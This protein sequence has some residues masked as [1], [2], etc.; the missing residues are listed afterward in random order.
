MNRPLN[1]VYLHSHDTGQ[2]IEPYGHPVETPALA[3][4]AR[5][6]VLFRN[7]TC[8]APTCSPSRAALLTGLCPHQP[9]N[10]ML[11]LAHFGDWRLEDPSRHLA[12][13]LQ[14]HGYVTALAGVQH[15]TGA[16]HEAIHGLG[17]RELLNHD[18]PNGS[19]VEEVTDS[20]AC[21]FLRRQASAGQPFFLSV[22]FS[23][24]HRTGDV[25]NFAPRRQLEKRGLPPASDEPC[26]S[27]V[28]SR[29][30]RAPAPFYDSPA[31][32]R[33]WARFR[34]G[35]RILDERIG[36]V[37]QGIDE[38]GL[39]ESTLVVITTDHGPPMPTM[40]G[41]LTE[42]GLRVLLMMRGPAG[43]GFE[44]G[45]TFEAMVSHL[46]VIPTLEA[47]LGLPPAA[48]LTGHCLLPLVR[49]EV[50]DSVHALTRYRFAEHNDHAAISHVQRSVFDGRFKLIRRFER[51]GGPLEGR[52]PFQC[53]KGASL[54]LYENLGFRHPPG[55]A[56]RLHDLWLDANEAHNLADDPDYRTVR[57]RLNEALEAWMLRTGDPLA[58]DNFRGALP[59]PLLP[60]ES[61]P[62][63][64]VPTVSS[65]E[66]R[67][68]VPE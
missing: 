64:S 34:N 68:L 12:A 51:S 41:N 16:S 28:D 53:D 46:D 5:E 54:S 57:A 55:E 31:M 10:G 36:K 39:R 19:R 18:G 56:W 24:T 6:G 58:A 26:G 4:F 8:A 11:G 59:P 22:G 33:E 30:L 66:G 13:R 60:Y 48:D 62:R 9:G 2:W 40:K 17:Y 14:R 52:P 27:D 25:N 49:G 23:E 67:F 47:L 32:R 44:G 42:A 15:E 3:A 63:R 38:A 61:V 20:A 37:L 21:A 29:Y 50:A 45:R 35:A 7:A 43:S 65:E 1:V